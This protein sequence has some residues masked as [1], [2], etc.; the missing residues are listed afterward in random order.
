MLECDMSV[1]H[2]KFSCCFLVLF[3]RVVLV[4]FVVFSVLWGGFAQ[5]GAL[6]LIEPLGLRTTPLRHSR[7]HHHN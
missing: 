1:Q 5:Q 2:R 3:S 7:Q 6:L 4:G